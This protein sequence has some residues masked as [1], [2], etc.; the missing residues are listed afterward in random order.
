MKSLARTAGDLLAPLPGNA[1]EKTLSTLVDTPRDVRKTVLHLTPSI[2][3]GGAEAMLRNLVTTM[4]PTVW[5]SVIVTVDGRRWPEAAQRLRAG[6]AEVHDLEADAF[7]R[8]N[9]LFRMIRLIRKIQPDVVQTWMHHAD[10]VGGWCAQ[11][12]GVRRVI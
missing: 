9:T 1:G 7:L 8:P 11:M 10:F 3:G 2:G 5:R 12:A 4:D 6:G